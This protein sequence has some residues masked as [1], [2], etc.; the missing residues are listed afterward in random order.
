MTTINNQLAAATDAAYSLDSR[1]EA[2]EAIAV[3]LV[4]NHDDRV[5][6]ALDD[7][8]VLREKLDGLVLKTVVFS[9]GEEALSALHDEMRDLMVQVV[10]PAAAEIFE[11]QRNDA[12]EAAGYD[13]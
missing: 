1:D 13:D 9:G 3:E 12:I 10:M 5:M 11:Q 4:E 6:D 2:I 7:D 8:D